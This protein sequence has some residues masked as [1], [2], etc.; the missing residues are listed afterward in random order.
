MKRGTPRHPKVGHLCELLKIK[1]PTAVGYLGVLWHFTAEFHHREISASLRTP[2][3]RPESTGPVDP[4]GSL[5][6]SSRPAH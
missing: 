1:I 6:R 4:E 3:L 5:R 2:E